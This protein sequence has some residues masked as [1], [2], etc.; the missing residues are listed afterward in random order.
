M[1]RFS[2][3]HTTREIEPIPIG[4]GSFYLSLSG[5][6]EFDI[7]EPNYD[8]ILEFLPLEDILENYLELQVK[9]VKFRHAP[10]TLP[11][12]AQALR[13][14]T[15]ADFQYWYND[16]NWH[17][18]D[19]EDQWYYIDDLFLEQQSSFITN[20]YNLEST[21]FLG[22]SYQGSNSTPSTLIQYYLAPGEQNFR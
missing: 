13:I 20:P 19:T 8:P 2:F 21:Y 17:P 10:L 1:Q 16:R 11:E 12:L 7:F 9:E 3:N 5:N 15:E 4:P 18:L 6:S 22:N 14:P